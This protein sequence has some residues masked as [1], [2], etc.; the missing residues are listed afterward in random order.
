MTNFYLIIY[1]E[2]PLFVIVVVE[3]GEEIFV[4][5]SSVIVAAVSDKIGVDKYVAKA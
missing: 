2:L 3:I 1:F 4:V 5:K